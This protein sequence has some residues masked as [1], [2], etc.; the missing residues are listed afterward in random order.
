MFKDQI[1]TVQAIIVVLIW[2]VHGLLSNI[3]VWRPYIPYHL[4]LT[5][6]T[7]I[8]VSVAIAGMEIERKFEYRFVD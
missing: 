7:C 6:C 1:Y 2:T 4:A 8:K 5:S 3:S